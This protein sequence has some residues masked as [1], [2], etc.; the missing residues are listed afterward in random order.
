M[1]VFNSVQNSVISYG[2]DDSI[3]FSKAEVLGISG[4]VVV[5]MIQSLFPRQKY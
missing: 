1:H 2:S 3:P 4:Q 5:V